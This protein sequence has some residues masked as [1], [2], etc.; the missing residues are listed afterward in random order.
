MTTSFAPI[1]LFGFNRPKHL[2]AT[3]ITLKNNLEA[4]Q[5]ELYFFCDGPRNKNDEEKISEIKK[6]TQDL[7]GFKKVTLQFKEKN[8]G[9]AESII[10]GVTSVVN[11]HGRV[12]VME[13]DLVSSPHFL[14]YMNEALELYQ[15]HEEVISIHGYVYPVKAVL[16]ETF[17]LKGADCWGWATWKRGWDLFNPNGQELLTELKTKKLTYEFDFNGSYGYTSML[18]NQIKGRNNSWAIRWYASAFL[19]NKLTLYP[20]KSLIQNIGLD[21]T[22]RHSTK[23]DIYEI[24]LNDDFT[25]L[26]I[27][28]PQESILA[29]ES[30]IQFFKS[31]RS[32]N[33]F[34]KVLYKIIKK[35]K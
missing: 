18:R 17:F 23:T 2:E 32:N 12:I 11:Q 10:Q 27:H 14:R 21:N 4:A 7:S 19:K 25:S 15:N 29:K 16:P 24:A 34:I 31:T 30:I 20:G 5:S 8:L 6:L 22:G 35:F 28:E 3:L 1:A 33:F 26:K 13:D 9:L